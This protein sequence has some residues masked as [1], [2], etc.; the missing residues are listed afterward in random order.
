M[1]NKI[2]YTTRQN[3]VIVQKY[4]R[5]MRPRRKKK[6]S[7]PVLLLEY[8][9][10]MSNW[11]GNIYIISLL[12]YILLSPVERISFNIHYIKNIAFFKLLSPLNVT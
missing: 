5:D 2:L 11:L 12:T 1:K 4:L 6:E 9:F 3:K 10:W 8:M 7:H